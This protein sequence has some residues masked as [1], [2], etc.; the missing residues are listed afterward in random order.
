MTELLKIYLHLDLHLPHS[1]IERGSDYLKKIVQQY[2]N[3]AFNQNTTV[4]VNN[5]IGSIKYWATVAGAMYI[6]I[7]QYGSFRSGLD[8]LIVDSKNINKLIISKLNKDGIHENIFLEERRIMTTTDRI[9]GL[10]LRIDRLKF[11]MPNLTIEE[12]QSEVN[13]LYTKIET[14]STEITDKKDLMLILNEINSME[15]PHL[16][17]SGINLEKKE[18]DIFSFYNLNPLYYKEDE[19]MIPTNDRLQLI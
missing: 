14:L 6:A 19:Y 8:Q 12:Y 18:Q 16:K 3:I 17:F 7:G 11:N 2:S 15:I 4:Y 1:E 10:F 5:D 13:N 9:R